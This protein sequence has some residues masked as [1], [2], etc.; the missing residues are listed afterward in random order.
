[1]AVLVRTSSPSRLVKNVRAAVQRGE[2]DRWD[3]D[4]DGDLTYTA[5]PPYGVWLSPSITTS[6]VRFNVITADG[7]D[8]TSRTYALVHAR[9]IQ[10]LLT[11][12][13]DHFT[14]VTATANPTEGDLL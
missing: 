10:M 5:R 2:V 6:G 12:F 3:C 13:D 11:Y 7:V 8:L 1:M 14:A 4:D 9:L